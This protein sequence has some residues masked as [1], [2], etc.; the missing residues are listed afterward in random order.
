M[1]LASAS[2]QPVFAKTRENIFI[3]ESRNNGVISI[4]R[5]SLTHIPS[6]ITC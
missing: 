5:V 1:N 3:S 2:E 6:N 4:K